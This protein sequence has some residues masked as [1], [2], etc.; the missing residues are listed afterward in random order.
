MKAMTPGER[1]G[2]V[3]QAGLCDNC[4]GRGHIAIN[5]GSKMK[6]QVNGCG[7]KHHTMLHLQKKNNDCNTP[8]NTAATTPDEN[9]ASIDI[10]SRARES[11][12]CR[13][14]GS[15]KK[16]V[17]LRIVPVV[18]KGQGRK[19]EIVTNASLDPRS[20]V[21]LC[22]VSLLEKLSVFGRPKEFTITTV[23]GASDSQMDSRYL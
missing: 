2:F 5:C 19:G 4:F 16:N 6:C 18:V 22:D 3:R 8:P 17:C 9:S 15:G 21:S 13:A 1:K 12:R 23:N 10:V 14:T 7:W 20:D 11:G